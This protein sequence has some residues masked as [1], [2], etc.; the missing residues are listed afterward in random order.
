MTMGRAI[1]VVDATDDTIFECVVPGCKTRVPAKKMRLHVAKHILKNDV[2]V[3]AC[4]YCGESSGEH[5][6]SLKKTTHQTLIPQSNCPKMIKFS[7]AAAAKAAGRNPFLNRPV[8]CEVCKEVYW[9]Y[10]LKKHFERSH[11]GHTCNIIVSEEE[12]QWV[13]SK[14]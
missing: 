1:E 13:L 12:K 3:F 6:I 8:A 10:A 9:S 5:K 11:I 14:K 2:D 7:L 4:G